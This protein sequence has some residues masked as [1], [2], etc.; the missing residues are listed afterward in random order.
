MGAREV[1]ESTVSTPLAS[2]ASAPV[3]RFMALLGVAPPM[4]GAP[5]WLTA[6]AGAA[7]GIAWPLAAMDAVSAWRSMRRGAWG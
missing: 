5:R 7:A 1:S 6:V 2:G 4:A 3:P